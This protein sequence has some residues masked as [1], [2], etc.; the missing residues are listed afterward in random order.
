MLDSVS[1]EKQEFEITG[2]RS[3]SFEA[4]RP[5]SRLFWG[6]FSVLRGITVKGDRGQEQLHDERQ[7]RWQ[8]LFIDNL[9]TVEFFIRLG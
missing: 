6:M 4:S 8:G 5:S 9:F 3:G 1:S 7:V 2:F